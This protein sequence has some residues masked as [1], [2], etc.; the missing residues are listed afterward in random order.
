MELSPDEAL[1]NRPVRATASSRPPGSH[2][3]T[4][5]AALPYSPRNHTLRSQDRCD[6]NTRVSRNAEMLS[7]RGS[8][9]HEAVLVAQTHSKSAEIARERRYLRASNVTCLQAESVT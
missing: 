9:G 2:D 8:M 4:P 1:W 6:R 3:G 5:K 7:W